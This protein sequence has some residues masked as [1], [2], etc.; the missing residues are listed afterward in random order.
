MTYITNADI[1]R[2]PSLRKSIADYLE[3]YPKAK[4]KLSIL[5]NNMDE[6]R[7]DCLY[8]DNLSEL[9]IIPVTSPQ[10]TNKNDAR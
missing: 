9:T 2:N 5:G 6:Q 8:C 10:T 3:K 1:I 7:V 4:I